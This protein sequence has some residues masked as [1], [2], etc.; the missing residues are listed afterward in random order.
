[1]SIGEK[2][3]VYSGGSKF[4]GEIAGKE[5]DKYIVKLSDGSKIV[6]SEEYLEKYR[7]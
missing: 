1:M 7:G 6:T 3:F 2:V 5:N 4:V